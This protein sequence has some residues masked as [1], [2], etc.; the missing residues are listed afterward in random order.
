MII[1]AEIGFSVHHFHHLQATRAEATAR[2]TGGRVN[3]AAP[4]S[5]PPHEMTAWH[6]FDICCIATQLVCASALVV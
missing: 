4:P 5:L 2:S 3:S 6:E 1:A